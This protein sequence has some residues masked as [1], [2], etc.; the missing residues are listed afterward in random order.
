MQ[1]FSDLFPVMV[2]WYDISQCSRRLR[3]VP[4]SLRPARATATSGKGVVSLLDREH[5]AVSVC[6][7]R[8]L[9]QALE[10]GQD[11]REDRR[12]FTVV[13]PRWLAARWAPATARRSARRSFRSLGRL[14]GRTFESLFFV[15]SI[16]VI[17]SSLGLYRGCISISIV[18]RKPCARLLQR[19]TSPCVSL[20]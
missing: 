2:L 4:S 7:D 17:T 10:F 18:G 11:L 5:H 15:F 9:A 12:L 14:P 3:K 16:T 13:Y 8:N 20:V 19:V 1:T 6:E